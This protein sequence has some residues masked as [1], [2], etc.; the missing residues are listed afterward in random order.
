MRIINLI[1]TPVFLGL[2]L[3]NSAIYSSSVLADAR[4]YMGS[5]DNKAMEQMMEQ[6]GYNYGYGGYGHGRRFMGP[7][8]NMMGPMGP[9]MM[10]RLTDLDLSDKQREQIRDIQSKM[11]KQHFDLMEKMMNT[12]DKLY[13]LY[14]QDIL[15]ADKIGEVYDEIYKIKRQMIQ[16]HIHIRNQIFDLLN[17]EQRKK[18]KESEPFSNGF[19]MMMH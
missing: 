13:K 6:R 10:G 12:S 18:F 19:G 11:R 15:N 1:K 3:C 7:M 8:D 16:E 5:I 9:M 2:I 14:D 17:K 4:S